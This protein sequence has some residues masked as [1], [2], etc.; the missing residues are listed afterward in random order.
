MQEGGFRRQEC[1]GPGSRAKRGESREVFSERE[2]CD[3]KIEDTWKCPERDGIG[4]EGCRLERNR[5]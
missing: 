1:A 4:G 3:R 2:R 5:E